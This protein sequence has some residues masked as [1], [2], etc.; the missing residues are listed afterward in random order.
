MAPP[1]MP[2]EMP[3]PAAPMAPPAAPGV[4]PRAGD[5]TAMPPMVGEQG[6]IPLATGGNMTV[7]Q[8]RP[9]RGPAPP[10]NY[11]WT[12]NGVLEP[13]PGGPA[14]PRTQSLTEAEAKANLF[15]TQMKMSQDIIGNVRAP[16]GVAIAAWRNAPSLVVNPLLNEND[17]QYFNAV[18]LFAAG[19][20]RKE[21][22]AA[23]TPGEMLDVHERF[24]PQPGDSAAVI[25]QKDRARQAAISSIEA[26]VRGGMRGGNAASGNAPPGSAAPAARPTARMR[27]NPQTNQLEPA[28]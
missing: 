13:I 10:A 6:R 17:Q 14:D 19:I 8:V 28:Q 24:F 25:Q 23:F 22:G 9:E 15:G 18:R 21:T 4:I 12:E 20:L 7:T 2:Q 16:S 5:A 27:W 26:E 1:A 3:A 11:R